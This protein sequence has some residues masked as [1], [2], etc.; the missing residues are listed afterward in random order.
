MQS[1][2]LLRQS[3]ILRILAL[4]LLVTTVSACGF[5]LRGN[6]PLP[7][8]IQN[9]FVEAPAG[10]FKDELVDVLS[11]GGAQLASNAGGADVVLVIKQ[12][13]TSRRVGTL[14]DRGKADSYNLRFQ[15]KYSLN[16]ADGKQ[17]REASLNEMRRYNFDPELVIESEQEEAELQ[18]DMERS[19]AL[20]IMRQ[21]STV[22][23][24]Q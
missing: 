4:G 19:I 20:R 23:A 16:A 10:T 8:G 15:V 14:D 12:A 5:H 13:A 2:M 7:S 21:L 17:L 24:L 22:T 6:I 9:M 11:N 3:L 18:A 1:S